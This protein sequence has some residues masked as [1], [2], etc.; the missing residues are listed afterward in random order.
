MN[1]FAVNNLINESHKLKSRI[2]FEEIPSGQN[3]LTQ[4]I[5]AMRDGVAVEI[6]YNSFWRDEV[7]TFPIEP[8]C[9][10]VFRQ[11]WYVVGRS[12]YKDQ[13]RIYALDRISK[14]DTTE[15]KFTIPTDFDGADYFYNSFGV[16]VDDGWHEIDDV[17]IKV[18][19]KQANYIRTLPLHHSQ[20][21]IESN[22][23]YTIFGYRLS[24]TYDFRQEILS[25]GERVE[26]LSPDYLRG[27]IKEILTSQI[28]M[29]EA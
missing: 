1:T 20:Q 13:L 29:Y 24:P 9:V 23:E 18:Y 22:E 16:V 11:R 10:K 4:I 14:L 3:Y 19:D 27:E 8:Y 7:Y 28:K 15:E 17:K 26:V 5:E 6:T 2:L 25:Q 12:P 21:E